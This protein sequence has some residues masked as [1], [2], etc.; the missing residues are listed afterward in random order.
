[1]K[2][3][4]TIKG[5]RRGMVFDSIYYVKVKIIL[6][7]IFILKYNYYSKEGLVFHSLPSEPISC[8]VE[9]P[10]FIILERK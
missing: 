1:M 6:I 2:A 3:P 4:G 9:F 7:E 10:N 5:N 8:P